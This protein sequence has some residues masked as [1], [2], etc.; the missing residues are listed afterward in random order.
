MVILKI[1]NNNG[2]ISSDEDG[3]EIVIMGKG[4]AFG[5]KTGQEIELPVNAKIFSSN[6]KEIHS[7]LQEI[8]SDIPVEYLEITEKIV[9]TLKKEYNRSLQDIIYISLTEHIH[10]AIERSR[11]GIKIKNP[12]L[13]EIKRLYKEEYEV[14]KRTLVMMEEQFGVAFEDDEAGFITYHIVNAQLDGGMNN[15][16]DITKITQEVLNVIKYKMNIEYNEDSTSYDRLITHLKFFAQRIL[17]H[18]VYKDQDDDLFPLLCKKYPQSFECT[19][20]ISRLIEKKYEYQLSQEEQ[21]YLMI[22]IQKNLG[23]N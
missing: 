3:K 7:R 15:I 9:N 10:A 22:H 13:Q 8:V 1:L 12:L 20:A 16:S 11:Q 17:S 14:A 18:S 23:A 6:N 2:F 4:V 19:E 5:K 21:M